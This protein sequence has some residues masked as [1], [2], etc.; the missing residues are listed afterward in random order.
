MKLL[1]LKHLFIGLFMLGAAGLALAL[2]PDRSVLDHKPAIDLEVMIPKAFDN[3]KLDQT[4]VMLISPDQ[5]EALENV[6]S[7]TLTRT[8]INSAGERI[9]L[10][11]AYGGEHGEGMQLHRPENCYPAQGFQLVENTQS[12]TLATRHGQLP[13]KRLVA[14][15][16]ARNEPITYWSVVGGSHTEFGWRMKIAQMRYTLTGVIPDGMLVRVSSIDADETGAYAIQTD[17]IKSMLDAMSESDR[18]RITG[19]L[20]S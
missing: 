6:Y 7:Q 5:Q 8:Y 9:M 20:Q 14:A 12:L 15:Q 13:V 18:R 1:S 19:E 11:I 17:F 10:S 3:W 16:G 4:I 2:K